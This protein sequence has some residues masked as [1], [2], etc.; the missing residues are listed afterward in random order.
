MQLCLD[1]KNPL[2][3]EDSMFE[4][5][6]H[7]SSNSSLTVVG[8]KGMIGIQNYLKLDD[9]LPEKGV[10]NLSAQKIFSEKIQ[11]SSDQKEE[12]YMSPSY[13]ERVSTLLK[14]PTVPPST[15]N[16]ENKS[17][18]NKIKSCDTGSG[19]KLARKRSLTEMIGHN[20]LS[21]ERKP[22]GQKRCFE[23]DL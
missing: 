14:T 10:S 7:E 1:G 2:Y 23:T 20:P 15:G 3:H 6:N 5:N 4:D 12:C 18:C 21:K 8:R 11:K 19:H 16:K 13:A 9:S 22:L 17:I